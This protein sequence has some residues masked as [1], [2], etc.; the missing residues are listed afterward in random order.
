MH[1]PL[2]GSKLEI[3]KRKKPP[4]VD[5][6]LEGDAL[7]RQMNAAQAYENS[8]REEYICLKGCF[9]EGFPLYF[10]NPF[11]GIDSQ[12]GDSWSLSYVK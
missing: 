9:Q 7:D 12:P 8:K 11:N 5:W 2:C 1:C 4:E 6:S 10:H 3:V